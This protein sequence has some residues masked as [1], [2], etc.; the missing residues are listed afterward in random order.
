MNLYA[1]KSQLSQ[2]GPSVPFLHSSPKQFSGLLRQTNILLE[3]LSFLQNPECTCSNPPENK[4]EY[5]YLC[6]LRMNGIRDKIW[7]FK[8]VSKS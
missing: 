1:N 5:L 6:K 8:K 3:N 2:I 7:N 4:I